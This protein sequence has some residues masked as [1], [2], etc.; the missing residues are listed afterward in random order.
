MYHPPKHVVCRSPRMHLPSLRT[1]QLVVASGLPVW[2]WAVP[3]AAGAALSAAHQRKQMLHRSLGCAGQ[4]QGL[5][6]SHHAAS[7][8]LL[9]QLQRPPF[10]LP[11][12]AG[13]HSPRSNSSSDR[14]R[15]A[16]TL[17]R[18]PA[19]H[20]SFLSNLSA[21]QLDAV[22][23]QEQHLRVIAG[24]G[25]GKTRVVAARVGWLLQQGASARSILAITFTRKV[26]C[27][28]VQLSC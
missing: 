4:Q 24:P 22:V 11:Q 10:S 5:C 18:A 17:T 28:H 8:T 3:R 14:V 13:A 20:P 27:T 6:T 1:L 16:H 15:A 23:A 19:A 7:K 26:C 2:S 25:S 9:R 12:R 21:E